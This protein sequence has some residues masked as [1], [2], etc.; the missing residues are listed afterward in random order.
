MD[1]L[2]SV[3]LI[4]IYIERERGCSRGLCR[5]Y[6]GLG[7]GFVKGLQGFRVSGVLGSKVLNN[8]NVQGL[9]SGVGV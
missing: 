2:A 7:L 3:R 8:G 9:G 1:Y 4:Y 6:I 5:V